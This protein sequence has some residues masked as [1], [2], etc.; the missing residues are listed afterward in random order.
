MRPST[1]LARCCRLRPM[2]GTFVAIECQAADRAMAERAI[3]AGFAAVR[4]V[5][6]WMHPTRTGSDLA[7]ICAAP[8]DRSV[9]VHP[10]TW[11]VLELSQ[12]VHASSG[13]CFDPC[14][15][16]RSGSISDV[17]LSQP[18][19]VVCTAPVSIDL[20][21][22]A[23]GFAVDRAIDALCAA[24]CNTGLV[25]AGGDM[26]VFGANDSPVWVR[27]HGGDRPIRLANQACA[28]SDPARSERPAEHRGYYSRVAVP[29]DLTAMQAAAVVAPTTAVADA[30]TKCVLL[31]RPG[32]ARTLEKLLADFG[33]TSL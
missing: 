18:G 25:N 21:G 23:K 7:V 11:D 13:G 1:D 5:D 20:G 26:R 16:E 6:E 12:R 29:F 30:L 19:R 33:A 10:W 22:I 32:R 2:L 8:L 14:L 27:T 3:E 31:L 28:V 24:G 4:C 17:D 15:A 9:P